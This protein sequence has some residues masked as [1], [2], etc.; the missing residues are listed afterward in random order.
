MELH[1]LL[2]ALKHFFFNSRIKMDIFRYK[3]LLKI[4][5]L[6]NKCEQLSR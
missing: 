1:F 3:K 5:Y 4:K 2:F 6:K